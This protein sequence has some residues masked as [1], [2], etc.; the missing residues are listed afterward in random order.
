MS[1]GFPRQAYWSGFPCP[2][3]EDLPDP[4]TEATSLMS[5]A[6]AGVFFTTSATW[7][8]PQRSRS[9][10]S[11][12]HLLRAG[13]LCLADPHAFQARGKD[14][15]LG[16]DSGEDAFPVPSP[17]PWTSWRRWPPEAGEYHSSCVATCCRAAQ[18]EIQPRLKL[19]FSQSHNSPLTPAIHTFPGRK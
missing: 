8:A 19:R 2:P 5:P 10:K 6:L 13:L 16:L 9:I 17:A 18:V 7:E 1:I 11:Q 4:G 14:G 12:N 3:P 15:L